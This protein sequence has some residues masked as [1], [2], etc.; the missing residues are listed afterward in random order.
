MRILIAGVDGYLGWSLAL[1]LA[2]RG[3][4]IGGIDNYSRRDWVAEMGSASATP[5]ARMTDRL[6]A[7]HERF[8]RPLAFRRGD[9][10][11]YAVV[12]D[13]VRS[14]RPDAIVHLGEQPSAPYSMIDVEHA[15]RTQVNNV[16][17]TLN[18]L[19]AMR[20]EC[21]AA[22]L[23]KLGSMGEYGTPDVDIPEGDFE[24]EYKGRSATLPFP[25]QPGSLYH[26]S[27]V[28]DSTNIRLACRAWG[29]RS[30]D[31]MQGVVYGVSAAGHVGPLA[32]RLDYDQCFGTVVN[33]FCAQ[34]VVGLPITPY[35]KG[36]QRRGML[37]MEDSM[38][39]LTLALEH[40]PASGGYRVLNQ[41][42]E[43]YSPLE[44]AEIVA[45]VAAVQGLEP[46][47]SHVENPRAE[48]EL[49]EHY[50]NPDHAR[51]AALGYVPLGNIQEE[52]DRLLR[53]MLGNSD[54]IASHAHTLTPDVRWD[55]SRRSCAFL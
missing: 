30:T 43:A 19:F 40:P 5:I 36:T 52:I 24:I 15:S 21:P 34:A 46:V 50:Y 55:G 8:G 53:V 22:H 14:F 32:T 44:I 16:V 31:I 38:Q 10:C 1:H 4:E 6:Q 42:D 9:L 48:V 23:L 27:K 2:E 11:D 41:F 47:V 18:I 49:T 3:H 39:C 17:S 20:D 25:C 54:R 33:R 28:H 45:K 26:A 35:G 13:V 51:L 29:L 37:P 12:R 7:F